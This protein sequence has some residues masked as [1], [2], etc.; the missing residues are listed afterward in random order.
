M[1]SNF[2]C[3][4]SL[5]SVCLIIGSALSSTAAVA[6]K[7]NG[8]PSAKAGNAARA[9]KDV[10][11]EIASI[12]PVKPGT[13]TEAALTF[14][15]TPDGYRSSLTVGQMVMLAY[16][17][18]DDQLWRGIPLVNWPAWIGGGDDWYVVNARVSDADRDAWRNQSSKHELLRTAM[19]DLLRD[20][21]K[22]VIHEK[23]TQV[24]VFN[25][26]VQKRGTKLKPTPVGFALPK[27]G[28]PLTSGGVRVP[29][30]LPEHGIRW[31]YYGATIADLVEFLTATSSG[32]SV[33]DETGL[34]GRYDFTLQLIDHPARNGDDEEIYNW[35]VDQLGLVLKPGKAIGFALVI[36]HIERPTEN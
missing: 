9:P 31:R 18:S 15:P 26:I 8:N 21:C 14:V 20:R 4:L 12:T 24:E 25:L 5:V 16:G 23:P 3:C 7:N 2:F 35:P 19:Q 1:F 32:R 13:R 28:G 11:F 10:K 34:T 6:Q 27:G 29:E 33:V 36:D 22:L 30:L 17:P